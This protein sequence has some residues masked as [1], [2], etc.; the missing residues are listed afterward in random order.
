MN[1]QAEKTQH[2][3]IKI[4]G[5]ACGGCANTVQEALNDIEGVKEAK[6]DLE[7]DAA[8]VTFEENVVSEDD[9]RE[10]IK[11]AGY[12]FKGISN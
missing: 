1:T 5:M 6:V 8:L 11:Q 3:A 12:E 9:F 2:A 4:G 7:N 10:A